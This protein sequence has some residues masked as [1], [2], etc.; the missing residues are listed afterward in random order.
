M[1]SHADSLTYA[2]FLRWTPAAEDGPRPVPLSWGLHW[3]RG[4]AVP[5]GDAIVLEPSSAQRFT[6]GSNGSAAFDL[7]S[8]HTIDDA[9]RYAAKHGLLHHGDPDGELRESWADWEAAIDNLQLVANY[10]TSIANPY[11]P[12]VS[13]AGILDDQPDLSWSERE[14]HAMS[15]VEMQ[16]RNHLKEGRGVRVEFS[17]DRRAYFAEPPHLLA[18]AYV[19]L[20]EQV[21]TGL[22]PVRCGSCS[23]SFQ[24]RRTGGRRQQFCSPR[25]AAT[26]RK[27]RERGQPA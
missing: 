4:P 23:R 7:L 25:C 26:A 20:A 13:E 1:T 16:V 6:H 11:E 24:P 5:R 18:L 21:V 19:D 9:C 22:G 14:R 8:V 10:A 2:E 3:L 27:R 17:P 15:A 12:G